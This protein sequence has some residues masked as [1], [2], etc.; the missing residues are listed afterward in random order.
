MQIS[1]NDDGCDVTGLVYCGAVT[2][3][4]AAAE[5][6]DG[7]VAHAVANEWVGGEALSGLA[8]TVGDVVVA[9]R[10]AFG[11]SPSDTVESVQ[12][13]DDASQT[14]RYF[15]MSDCDFG[16]GESRF[17]REHLPNGRLRFRPLLVSFLFRQG[18]LTAP[19]RNSELAGLLDVAY[20]ARVP[21]TQV[22]TQLLETH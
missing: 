13:W 22:R 2:A 7:F 9:N 15:A 17:S 1:V 10:R 5:S 4:V 6:W 8:G 18:D 14:Q 16:E 20:G 19:I 3:T 21:I 12:V 11:Q